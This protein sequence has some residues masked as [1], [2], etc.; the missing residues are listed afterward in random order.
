M[1]KHYQKIPYVTLKETKHHN[2]KEYLN[3]YI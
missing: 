2:T 1:L 3:F